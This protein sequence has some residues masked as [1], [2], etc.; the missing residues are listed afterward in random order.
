MLS[1]HTLLFESALFLHFLLTICKITQIWSPHKFKV[2][3]GTL[4]RRY[5]VSVKIS[6]FF[7]VCRNTKRNI[8]RIDMLFCKAGIKHMTIIRNHFSGCH[9]LKLP[10]STW[11][12][13]FEEEVFCQLLDF[14]TGSNYNKKIA[15]I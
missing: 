4:R 7:A 3:S 1:Q 12:P 8:A 10:E 2:L 11:C 5:P 13:S 15:L 14:F 6:P 9:L